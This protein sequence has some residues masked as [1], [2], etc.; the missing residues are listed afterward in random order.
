MRGV[1]HLLVNTASTTAADDDNVRVGSDEVRAVTDGD[2]RLDS[3]LEGRRSVQIALPA[4]V[5]HAVWALLL[6]RK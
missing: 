4:L 6:F 1:Q 3:S 5:R 2:G